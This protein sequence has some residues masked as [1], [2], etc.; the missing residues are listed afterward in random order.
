MAADILLYDI[1]LVPVGKDQKQHV[2]YARDIAGKFNTNFGDMFVLPQAK[3][4]TFGEIPGID[5][6]KM[7]KSYDNYIGIME[8]PEEIYKK[9]KRILTDAI[10]VEAPKDPMT[11][12]LYR[13]LLPLM[14]D[15]EKMRI[16]NDYLWWG[17]SYKL[18]KDF[19]YEKIVWFVSPL[20]KVY[21]DISDDYIDTL[22]INHTKKAQTIASHTMKRVQQK[23]FGA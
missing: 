19:L 20:Q 18:L 6:R 3:I 11:D 16:D 13:I 8:S 1:D 22:I 4:T 5:W 9:V 17:M 15:A 23:I 21:A 10:P 2:E 12:V 14:S 7:S